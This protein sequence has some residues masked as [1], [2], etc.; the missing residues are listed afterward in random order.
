MSE[1]CTVYSLDNMAQLIIP[2]LLHKWEL[3]S[4]CY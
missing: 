3:D 4:R 2:V 1:F